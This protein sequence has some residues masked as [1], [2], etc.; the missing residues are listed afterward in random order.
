MIPPDEKNV[1]T[2]T[3]TIQSGSLVSREWLVAVD[4]LL[5]CLLHRHKSAMI[6]IGEIDEV[7]KLAN[8]ARA[9]SK[10]NERLCTLE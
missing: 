5:S 9:F 3:L 4:S 8:Q 6:R 2:I 10:K 1:P 7:R